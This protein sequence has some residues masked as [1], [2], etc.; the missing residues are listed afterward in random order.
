[1]DQVNRFHTDETWRWT[2]AEQT[3]LCA[4]L[5]LLACTHAPQIGWPRFIAAFMVMDLVGYLPGALAYRR[6]RGEPIAPLYHHLYNVTHSYLSIFAALAV[7]NVLSGWEWAM[8]APLIHL[9]GD[10]GIFGNEYK[11][12][13]LPFEQ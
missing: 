4:G 9:A 7:W 6:A 3:V 2:R 10:R 12:V 8:L 5:S 11:P 13:S 1:M